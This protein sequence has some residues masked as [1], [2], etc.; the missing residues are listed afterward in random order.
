MSVPKDIG[1]SPV[2]A[3]R[4]SWGLTASDFAKTLGLPAHVLYQVEAG[5]QVVPRRMRAALEDLGV[6]MIDLVYQQESWVKER[7]AAL[8]AALRE[9]LHATLRSG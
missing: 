6:D 4:E 2:R 1:V 8:R 3:L 7:G 5:K 9:Q